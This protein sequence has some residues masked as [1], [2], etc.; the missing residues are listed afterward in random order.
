MFVSASWVRS[1]RLTMEFF[2]D[3]VDDRY[4][5]RPCWMRSSEEP[6][7]QKSE[8]FFWRRRGGGYCEISAHLKVFRSSCEIVGPNQRM[9]PIGRR[10]AL[11]R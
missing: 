8:H 3:L 9:L 4:L 5:S 2:E 11:T 10:K 1:T 6:A 7:A